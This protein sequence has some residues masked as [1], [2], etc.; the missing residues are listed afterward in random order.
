MGL[1]LCLFLSI[2][3]VCSL[4]FCLFFFNLWS[5]RPV[6]FLC[7]QICQSFSL[8]L[9]SFASCLGRPFLSRITKSFSYGYFLKLQIFHPAL[10]LSSIDEDICTSWGLNEIMCK[11]S[12][13]LL[14]PP[15][16]PSTAL[17]PPSFI[18][19]LSELFLWCHGVW[20]QC[21][22]ILCPSCH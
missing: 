18:M 9:Q 14:Q 22:G 4:K 17:K 10:S 21:L 7:I 11:G 1:S 3:Y 6:T 20:A 12:C 19:V 2:G 5:G 13:L 8:W 15:T 16:F